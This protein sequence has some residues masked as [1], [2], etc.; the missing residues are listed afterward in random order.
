MMRMQLYVSVVSK[1]IQTELIRHGKKYPIFTMEQMA[2]NMA[3]DFEVK[4]LLNP[5]AVLDANLNLTNAALSTFAMSSAA[6][7]IGV[8]FLDN[9]DKDIYAAGW[10]PRIRKTKGKDEFE[11]TYKK[12]YPVTCEAV[13]AALAK[14]AEDGFDA[15]DQSKYEAQV[16]W[17]YEKMTLSISR[18][19]KVPDA[20]IGSMELLDVKAAR[21]MLIDEAPGKFNDFGGDGW[22][23]RL[24]G[25]ARIYGPIQTKRFTGVWQ[26]VKVT[27]EIWP[28]VIAEEA[29]TEL[30][31]EVSFKEDEIDDSA[32]L[33]SGL[34]ELLR[35]KGWLCPRDSLKTQLI[36]DNY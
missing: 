15:S 18:S 28:V 14:A 35:G 5:A 24:L 17:G 10:S 29:R 26:G 36:M 21:T 13:D 25:E 2:H 30:I 32:A 8:L 1:Y 27:V 12:R 23:E 33:R 4:L 7:E 9:D 16:E 3:P 20:G 19:K 22:G 6:A 11:L 31:V 34:I